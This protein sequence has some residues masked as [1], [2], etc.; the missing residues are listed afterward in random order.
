M[1]ILLL[2][3]YGRKSASFRY[4]LEQYLPYLKNAGYSYKVES[5]LTDRYLEHKFK[6]GKRDWLGYIRVFLHRLS[7]FWRVRNFGLVIIC[8]EFLPYFPPVFEK[9]LKWI[10]IP[11][12]F[13]YDDPVFHYYDLSG[14]YIVKLA[15]GK[16][17]ATV[18]S[19]ASYII[20]GSPYLVNFSKQFNNNVIYLP[21]VVDPSHYNRVKTFSNKRPTFTIGWIGSPSTSIYLNLITPAL[22]NICKQYDVRIVLI[23]AGNFFI[24]DVPVEIKTWTEKSEVDLL[25]EFDVGIMP[26]TDDLWSQ[27]KCGFKLVQYMAC[28]LPV[29][30]SPVGVNTEMVEHGKNG[31]LASSIDE[32]IR[33]FSNLAEDKE[34]CKKMGQHSR[35]TFENEY[36]LSVT[37]PKFLS[38]IQEF[39]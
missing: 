15:F 14:N 3:K 29:I 25:L 1:R 13:D 8:V 19:N 30:A 9:Y 26:L 38:I 4:R 24:E 36:S 22:K 35:I 16:K 10:N 7:L 20:G 5:L 32:W 34:L 2:H 12:I 21:T 33:A 27:G 28:G 31:F 17:Y 23:G 11:Y 18:L 6:T 39:L 37:A